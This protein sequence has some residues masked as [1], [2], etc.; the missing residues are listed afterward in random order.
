M[1]SSLALPA[2]AFSPSSPAMV[3]PS[4]RRNCP[5]TDASRWIWRA[6]QEKGEGAWG[7]GGGGS[8]KQARWHELGLEIDGTPLIWSQRNTPFTRLELE[9]DGEPHPVR[10]SSS[11]QFLCIQQQESGVD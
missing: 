10:T 1:P 9:V 6:C 4:P 5:P 11:M 8:R 3:A 7:N 2:A